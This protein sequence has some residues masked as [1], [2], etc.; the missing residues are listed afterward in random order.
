M[1][2]RIRRVG[3]GFPGY[4]GP[5]LPRGLRSQRQGRGGDAAKREAKT[6]GR[7]GVFE[8]L[9]TV[10]GQILQGAGGEDGSR[11]NRG[12][13]EGAKG[14]L[15]VGVDCVRASLESRKRSTSGGKPRSS[16]D[17]RAKGEGVAHVGWI[18]DVCGEGCNDVESTS[19][20]V[21]T[22]SQEEERTSSVKDV[23]VDE[24]N[25]T[26][27]RMDAS[28]MEDVWWMWTMRADGRVGVVAQVMSPLLGGDMSAAQGGGGSGS[29][30]LEAKETGVVWET[31]GGRRDVERVV[32]EEGCEGGKREELVLEVRDGARKAA[33]AEMVGDAA[34]VAMQASS[35]SCEV[36]CEELEEWKNALACC[37]ADASRRGWKEADSGCGSPRSCCQESVVAGSGA[38]IV[39][40]GV[41]TGDNAGGMALVPMRN[42]MSRALDNG[43]RRVRRPFSV[44]EVEALVHAVEK[45]GTGRWRDVKLRAFEQAKHRTYVDLK[46][47]WKTLVHTAR[48][49]PH[50]RRGEPV[51]QELLE[52]VTRA[53]AFWTAHAAK[54]QAEL[55]L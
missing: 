24:S 39:H 15:E 54:Q 38:M 40:P 26:A 14:E 29:P 19:G 34:V 47:K 49:A 48:I 33:E 3:G 50:Q 41:G 13:R 35:N 22:P 30:S 21:R 17:G 5:A 9:A 31:D 2:A 6:L 25:A 23:A 44:S 8:L 36:S 53:H 27:A 37:K 46:D 16:G 20:V 45:L 42:K 28:A 11:T 51:P 1:E 12:D 52:R 7:G 32:V 18:G 43:K 4:D 10:A 55:D